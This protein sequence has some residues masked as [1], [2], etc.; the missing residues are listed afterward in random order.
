MPLMVI[1]IINSNT[2]SS[3]F[4]GKNSP[5]EDV[6]EGVVAAPPLAPNWKLII[7]EI[8]GRVEVS[9]GDLATDVSY[10]FP[11]SSH[12]V[13]SREAHFPS[14]LYHFKRG[15][16]VY[17]AGFHLATAFRILLV[18]CLNRTI[19]RAEWYSHTILKIIDQLFC[20][21]QYFVKFYFL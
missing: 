6:I 7:P 2:R 8:F 20:I 12:A 18:A 5:Y 3:A 1:P 19:S 16:K 10:Q 14:L 17:D 21:G 9:C 4:V 13:S 11:D 15:A